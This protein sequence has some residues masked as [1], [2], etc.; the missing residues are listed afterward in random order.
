M[1]RVQVPLPGRAY[2]VWVGA[3]AAQR[4]ADV[5]PEG[6]QARR[7]RDA[8][9]RARPGD[10]RPPGRPLRGRRRGAS[11]D[12]GHRQG[13]V[14]R[15]PPRRPHPGGLRR[16]RD[17]RRTGDR[18]GWLRPATT[19][20]GASPGHPRT[21]HVARDDRR[22]HRGR[23]RRQPAG[24]QEPGRRLLAAPRCSATSTPWPRCPAGGPERPRRD[25]EVPLPD[26]GRPARAAIE[27]R[28]AACVAIKAAVVAV[29]N[30]RPRPAPAPPGGPSSTTATPSPTPWRSTR[31]RPAPRRGGGRRPRVRGRAGGEAG[32]DRPGPRRRP[33]TL[34]DLLRP[35][36]TLPAGRIP[37]GLVTLIAHEQKA[38][39]G[40]TF[41]LDGPRR[42][43]G[44]QASHGR[45]STALARM[46]ASGG[47]Q[48]Q[49]APAGRPVVLLLHGPNLNLLGE[50]EPDV[51]GTAT[52]ADD[53]RRLR[54]QRRRR[55][56]PRVEDLQEGQPR[57]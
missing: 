7:S 5:L 49:G 3:G 25:G 28:V 30:R 38:V 12:P 32:P 24:G 45:P 57:G 48:A 13:A 43:G 19:S 53:Y 21:D 44:R 22:R 31:T 15:L 20:T 16:C 42:R 54:P 27:E 1:I 2:D 10:P 40:L 37:P 11:Q 29:T 39:D 6:R 35:R 41:V 23:D 26:R 34:L 55:T 8:G 51:Y 18:R 9:R 46:G 4:L 36:A 17:R 52:L 33:P 50:R 56:R 47:E 14:P